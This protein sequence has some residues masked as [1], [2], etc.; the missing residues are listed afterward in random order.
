VYRFDPIRQQFA[1]AVAFITGFGWFSATDPNPVLAP[2]EG[3][4]IQNGNATALNLTFVGEVPQGSLSVA[5]VPGFQIVGSPVPQA[6][7]PTDLG[8]VGAD[9]DSI[10]QWNTSTQGYVPSQFDSVFGWDPPLLSMDV[11]DAFFLSKTTAGS[12]T[13]TFSVG[14]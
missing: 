10:Y 11:G 6:G 13:R 8:Y 2:G 3:F 14:Q 12:W 4:F 5:L 1:D 9:G 7:T